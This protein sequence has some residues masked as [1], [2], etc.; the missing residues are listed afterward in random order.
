MRAE[1]SIKMDRPIIPMRH[2]ICPGGYEVETNDGKT[3]R[4]DFLASEGY[5]NQNDNTIIDFFLYHSDTD[6]F[7]EMAELENHLNE[8]VKIVECFVYTGEYDDPE[9]KP[10]EILHFSIFTDTDKWI[11]P[12]VLMKTYS[13]EP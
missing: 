12:S 9:I 10:V 13:F 11:A 1:L 6:S 7:P 5:V 3:Y 4:F 2:Y 8:I